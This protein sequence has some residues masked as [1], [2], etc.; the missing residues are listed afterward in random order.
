ML[1]STNACLCIQ[2]DQR[3]LWEG[4]SSLTKQELQVSDLHLPH[5]NVL[6]FAV[7]AVRMK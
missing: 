5:I 3:I 2:D 7:M 1:P 6:V 4:V